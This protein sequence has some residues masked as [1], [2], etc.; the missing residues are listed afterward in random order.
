M[1]RRLCGLILLLLFLVRCAD[2]VW[3][4]GCLPPRP[5]PTPTS[6][7][8][9]FYPIA[10][11]YRQ[12]LLDRMAAHEAVLADVF[13]PTLPPDPPERATRPDGPPD[14]RPSG[15]DLLYTLMSL[16]R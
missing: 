12:E 9:D 2:D 14:T 6:S 5:T 7:G 1:V 4:T 11:A 8:D 10:A 15:P 16:R 3:E 13:V